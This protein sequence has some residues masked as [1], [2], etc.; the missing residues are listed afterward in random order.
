MGNA[1][2][3]SAHGWIEFKHVLGET[4]KRPVAAAPEVF[5]AAPQAL[6]ARADSLRFEVEANGDRD[7]RG[8]GLTAPGCWFVPVLLQGFHCGGAQR[9]GPGDHADEM[10]LTRRTHHRIDNHISSFE[11]PQRFQRSHCLHRMNQFRW[12]DGAVF[13]GDS[14]YIR[15]GFRRWPDG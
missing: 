9:R 8:N 12:N 15:C 4:L 14:F 6:R 11:I 7:V 3:G 10:H 1:S 13:F 2:E 5:A